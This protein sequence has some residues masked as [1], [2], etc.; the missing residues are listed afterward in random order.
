MNTVALTAD[1]ARKQ[2]GIA[3]GLAV[4][5]IV[6]NLVEGIVSTLMGYEDETLALFGFG[7]DSFIEMISGIGIAVMITR[8]RKNPNS[9]TGSFETAALKVT[10]YSFYALVAGLV[11]SALLNIY[12][13]HRPE[14]TL[15]G[16]G[17]AV[18][19][20]IVMIFLLRAKVRTGRKLNSRAIIADAHCTKV[21]IY[22]SLVLLGSS[23]IYELT[24]IGYIDAI[25]TLGLAW[26]CYQEGKE[27]FEESGHDHDH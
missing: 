6:Y 20:I 12:N 2:Y 5:T 22:M 23:L 18:A 27:C 11:V 4:F 1:E 3:Y 24:A 13:G 9:P 25:G 10:G 7:V 19:S 14:T 26:F 17:I 16:V 21:C 15:W 8:I